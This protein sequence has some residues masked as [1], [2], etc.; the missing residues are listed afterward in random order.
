MIKRAKSLVKKVLSS[1]TLWSCQFEFE[2]QKF[3]RFNE[4]PIEYAFAFRQLGAIYPKSVLDVGT[5]TSALPALFRTSGF[6]VTA[7]DNVRDYWPAGM[8]NRHYHIVDDD[9]TATRLRQRFDAVT[10]ISVLEHVKEHQSAVRDMLKLLNPGGHLILTCPY[11]EDRYVPNVYKE[12]GSMYGQDFA[13]VTQSYSRTELNSWLK[14]S[15]AEII[16][17][18][19]WQFWDGPCWTVGQQVIPPRQVGAGDLHQHTCLLIRKRA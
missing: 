9:M 15:N 12:A 19:F 18:E 4:R 7:T 6:L 1:F 2:R 3:E 5:G 17:Q 13:F 8:F 16:E 14:E 10:C 11:T